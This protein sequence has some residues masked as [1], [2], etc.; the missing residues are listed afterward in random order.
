V[1]VRVVCVIVRTQN[2][3]SS[4][5]VIHPNRPCDV[6]SVE[7]QR[8]RVATRVQARKRVR[9]ANLGARSRQLWVHAW[10]LVCTRARTQNLGSSELVHESYIQRGPVMW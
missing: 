5:G 8:T 7:H 4:S 3:G 1:F 6:V 10:G 2:L 9:S